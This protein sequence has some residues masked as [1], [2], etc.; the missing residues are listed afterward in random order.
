MLIV[1]CSKII[2]STYVPFPTPLICVHP[3]PNSAPQKG[4]EQYDSVILY[5]LRSV[6]R[7]ALKA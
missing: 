1:F 6:N 3:S 7:L 4:S 5:V 2:F